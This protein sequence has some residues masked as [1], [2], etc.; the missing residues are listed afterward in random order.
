M[1]HFKLYINGKWIESA[2]K[3]KFVS[4]NKA[5]ADDVNSFEQA[6]AS[7]VDAAC[8]A[9]RSAFS[10]WSSLDGGS[11]SEYM[12]KIAA[13]IMKRRREMA[14]FESMETGK[15]IRESFNFDIRVSAWAFEYFAALAR[16]IR[17]DIIPM[18]KGG[19]CDPDDFNFV[20]YEPYGVAAVIAPFNFPLHLMT[21]SLAPA[22]AAG[23][24]CIL[25]ASSFTPSTTAI[26]GEI[27]DEVELPAGVINIVHGLGSQVGNALVGN[28]EVDIVG[29]TGSEATGREL[30]RISANSPVIKKCLLELGGKGPVIVEP[31]ADLDL[32]VE[33]QM[34]GFTFNQGEVCCAMTRV[35][36]HKSV[37]EKYLAMLK[38]R[39]E[40]VKIG[41][42]LD[43]DAEMGCLISEEHLQKVERYVVDAISSGAKLLCGGK[44]YTEGVCANGPYY[45]PT[46]LTNVEREMSVWRE[47]VF[48]PVLSVTTYE[49]T[50]SAVE[51]ANDTNFGLG[52]N[53]FTKDLKKAYKM[54]KKINAGMV[55][56][57]MGNGMH[58]ATPFGGNKNS[59]IGREYGIYGIREYLKPKSNTWCMTR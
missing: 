4:K 29:F 54:A 28:K 57:N 35:I 22:L 36:I 49:D 7:D 50:N 9:A 31:D 12:M 25:K 18:I 47:E 27:C 58:M 51:M 41:Y 32:A 1:K 30:L 55:W 10:V 44:R 39:C 3:K 23:N 52:S 19:D 56:V 15:P 34:N 45:Q 26:L 59:G 24:T 53:I 11:R 16:E 48:G 46:V 8:N 38:K 43:E 6:S 2:E 21:R 40:A 17:G 20:T 37:A 42:P 14:E 13:A 5:N 33:A